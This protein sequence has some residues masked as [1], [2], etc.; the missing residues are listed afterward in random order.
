[1][2]WSEILSVVLIFLGLTFFA[3]GTVGLLRFPDVYTRL[4]ALTKADNVGLSL[5]IV[6]LAIQAPDW[7]AVAKLLLVWLLALTSSATACYLV[8]HCALRTGVKPE[9]ES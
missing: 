4:H 1:M 3:L 9:G 5:V 6:G 7:V 2:A 8:A